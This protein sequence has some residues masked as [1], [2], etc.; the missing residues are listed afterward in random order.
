[1]NSS[2]NSIS[3]GNEKRHLVYLILY[4]ILF[5][6]AWTFREAYLI[7]VVRE[8][9]SINFNLSFL[10]SG[11]IKILVW[12]VP[13]LI[14]LKYVDKTSP[15]SYLKINRNTGNG[16]LWGALICVVY[17]G[18]SLLKG[19][20][21][22]KLNVNL[23]LGFDKWFN[24]VILAGLTEEIV[25][26]GFLLQKIE[27]VFDFYFDKLTGK[28]KFLGGAV[29]NN[30]DLTVFWAANILTSVLFVIIHFPRWHFGGDGILFSS[31]LP[32]FVLG[33]AFGYTYKKTGSIWASVIFH[34]TNNFIVSAIL[35][36]G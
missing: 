22:G 1:M 4:I 26:R 29:R 18:S 2:N 20:F 27:S 3:S 14:Y 5:Y 16:L 25:F 7:K 34:S 17:I 23:N 33:M 10:I 35:M 31:M 11:G 36:T 13:V 8:D 15:L 30:K 24:T 21:S 19:Y 28:F 6:A 32:V 12:V 9:E